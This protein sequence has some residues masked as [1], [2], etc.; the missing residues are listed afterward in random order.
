[1]SKTIK[2]SM[3]LGEDL[4]E[5]CVREAERIGITKNAYI[6]TC[7]DSVKRQQDSMKMTFEASE[8][9]KLVKAEEEENE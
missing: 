6:A 8:L 7:I 4:N 5:Y 2:F 3:T 9:F 1:M